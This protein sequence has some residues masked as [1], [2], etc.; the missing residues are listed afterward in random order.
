MYYMGWMV[1]AYTPP[2]TCSMVDWKQYVYL[3]LQSIP[4]RPFP[5]IPAKL[6][7]DSSPYGALYSIAVKCY[8]ITKQRGLKKI[9]FANPAKRKE[10]SCHTAVISRSIPFLQSVSCKPQPLK[11]QLVVFSLEARVGC[12]GQY[13]SQIAQHMDALECPHY[14]GLQHWFVCKAA[15]LW[16]HGSTTISHFWKWRTGASMTRKDK[17]MYTPASWHITSHPT[18]SYGSPPYGSTMLHMTCHTDSY[19]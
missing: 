14:R 16:Q 9:D 8:E 18:P 1:L 7:R 4:P 13:S 2:L 6:L 15:L 17:A 3:L 5:K 10:V 12:S 19:T 11:A